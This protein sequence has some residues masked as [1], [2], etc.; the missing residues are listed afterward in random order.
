MK[1]RYVSDEQECIRKDAVVGQFYVL[2]RHLRGRTE[3][4]YETNSSQDSWFFES[5]FEPGTYQVRSRG[6]N[7]SATMLGKTM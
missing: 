6:A 7:H 5:G 3:E 2:F 1:G 4:K